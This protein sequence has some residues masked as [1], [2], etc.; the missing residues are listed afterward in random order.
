MKKP[1][2]LSLMTDKVRFVGDPI[3]VVVAE[4]LAQAK[5]AAEAVEVDIEPLPAVTRRAKPQSPARRS[6]TTTCRQRRARLSLRRSRQ[7]RGGLLQG[8]ARHQAPP[9]QQPRCRERDGAA[10]GDR[11][12]DKASGRFTLNVGCQGAFGMKGQ[13]VDILGVTPD[14]VH[15]LVGNVGG[16]FGMKAAVYPEYVPILHAAKELGRPGEVDGR[17]LRELRLGPSRPRP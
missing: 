15:V 2:R 5:D 9:G 14:K 12:F 11:L 8:R 17:P 3:A 16:S 10:R 13:L 1:K 7:G 6:F 4:T